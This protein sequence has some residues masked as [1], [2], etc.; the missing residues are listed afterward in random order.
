MTQRRRILVTSAL[1]YANGPLHL[2]HIL[3][4]IQ[5]D[6]WVRF[7][8]LRGHECYYVCADD[9]HG[10]PIMLRAQS[11]GISPEQ[12][13]AQV[14]IEHQRDLADML[15][16][17][18]NFGSTHS[19]ENK[20]LCDRMYL[21]HR[22]A[23]YIEKRSVRQAY[24]ETANMFLPD[25]YVKG[26][27]PVCATPD[28]YGDSCE[29]CGSTY[30]PA[31]LKNPIS[32]V[33]GTAPV[34]RESEHYF[35]KL[36]AF[37]KPLSAWVRS[38]AVQESVA[39]KLNEW[40]SQG[41]RDWDISRDAPYFGFEIPGAPGKYFYVWFD[42]P[43]GYL[44]SF[45][46]LCARTGLEFDDFLKVDSTAELHHFIGK[47]IL[48]FHTLF[49]P[50][51]LQASAMRRP[52]AVHTHGFLTINGQKMSKSRGTFITARRYL[53]NFPAEYLRY[54]F[55]AKLGSGIDDMDMNLDEFA[56]RLNAE[57]VGKLVNIASRCAGFITKTSAGKLA[58]ALAD[59]EM[60]A[61]FAA[62]GEA[63]AKAYEGRDTAGAVRDIMALADRANQYV[64]SRKPWMLAKDPGNVAEVQSVCTQ[65]LNLFRVLMIYLQPV[66]PQMSARAGA[67]F[68]EPDW[69]WSDAARPLLSTTINAYEPL[70]VRLDPKAVA[71][72]V[73]PEAVASSSAIA[74]A[75]DAATLAAAT[76]VE[77]NLISIDDFLRID[78]R[79]AKVLTAELVAGADKL[80]KLRV[81][82][83]EL[84][85]REIFAGIR[86]AY[87]PASLVG[88]LIV[89]V[90]NLE[91]RKMRFGTS[92]G[93]MLAAGPGGKDIFS[94]SPDSGATPG[95]RV[96]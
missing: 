51:V 12:L 87:D 67:F 64:D 45:T 26:I 96:R 27:C 53:Q 38:G 82:L 44:A 35:F 11:E 29:N 52:T 14:N 75:S 47:D 60:Y 23:G 92:E 18:D 30:T 32:V 68:R 50:A 40:F 65:A 74:G 79:V 58:D 17:M 69:A 94:L 28:Q 7:Q 22:D 57:I 33:S 83:G 41:L 13:I 2:G 88:R 89:V 80:L 34:W 81:D 78:L 77:G 84:G 10:T 63:I 49:W 4:T 3:E 39:R 72:L 1:P 8:K 85:Q 36:S 16:G 25:R 71:G 59:S 42:A 73:E 48:Y 61:S 70:A 62:A 56:T 19:A 86:A 95:M 91:P 93:M 6:I 15:I 37:E 31:D 24:D 20:V 21:M 5:T 9:T 55:A 43:I 46:Q 90:A 66:L 54:Y 76:S